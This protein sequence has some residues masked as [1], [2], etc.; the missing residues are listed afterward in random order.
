MTKLH[1]S[2]IGTAEHVS[3]PE[4][5][6]V[7]VPA[8]IDTGADSSAIWATDIRPGKNG[9][10]EFSLFGP[11]S[12]FYTGERINTKS[13]RSTHVKNSF[14]ATES[15][16]KARLVVAIGNRKIR[17]WFGLTDRSGM[18]Y[19]V[20]LGRR[21]LHK[22]FVVD[23]S[24]KH[25]NTPANLSRSVLVLG[26]PER[27]VKPFF[28][29]VAKQ[30][31]RPTEIVSRSLTELA[32]WVEPGNI[33]V[34]ETVTGRDI[35][36]FG[37]VYFK[38]HKVNYEFAIA[39]A[40]YLHFCHVPFFDRELA[41]HI[42]YDK[43]SEIMTLA[44]QGF[45]VPASYCARAKALRADVKNVLKRLGLPLVCKEINS[46][47]G[48]KNYLVSSEEELLRILD[49]SDT[50]D[51]FLLQKFIPNDGFMRALVLGSEVGQVVKRRIDATRTEDYAK[52]LNK[53]AGGGNA[54]LVKPAKVPAVVNDLAVR[55]ARVMDRQIAGID[56][57]QD[58][59]TKKWYILEVNS[60]PQ[61]RSGSFVDAK[62]T[63]I[64]KFFD[65]ELNR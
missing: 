23:V 59:G 14:G 64:A 10:L 17:A 9:G 20:L 25:I 45:D 39:A 54:S 57:V 24:Q 8:K 33:Q 49:N 62:V 42:S 28:D 56:L 43:L 15:R 38:T 47:R 5:G 40:E 19:P 41:G 26:A 1:I 7:N 50:T 37:L 60:A 63:E 6:F 16:Y 55:A 52:H 34:V 22:K 11:G 13:F 51:K 53:P 29:G 21:L 31:K 30:M 12:K 27:K 58:I 35:A 18:K 4:Y 2:T 36:E 61:I 32:F 44:L 65:K 46:D 3:L 48:R